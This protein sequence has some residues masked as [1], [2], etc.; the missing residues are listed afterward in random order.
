MMFST[1]KPKELREEPAPVPF[2]SPQMSHVIELGLHSEKPASI[3]EENVL[4]G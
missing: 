4:N 1:G 2:H 3:T